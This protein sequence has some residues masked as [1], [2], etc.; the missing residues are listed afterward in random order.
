MAVKSIDGVIEPSS[1]LSGFISIIE[2]I[3]TSGTKEMILEKY[4]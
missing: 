1:L 4:T 2:D 3:D